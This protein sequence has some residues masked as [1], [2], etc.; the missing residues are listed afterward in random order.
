[1]DLFKKLKN[2]ASK[3]PKPVWL[4]GILVPGGLIAISL[5]LAI[6]SLI[7]ANKELDVP[8]EELAREWQEDQE[9]EE[10]EQR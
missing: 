7:E 4:T 8:F 6:R 2:N 1:M 3:V 5:Y 9:K 10:N